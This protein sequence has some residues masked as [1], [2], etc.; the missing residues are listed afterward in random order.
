V[1]VW[2]LIKINGASVA[3][4]GDDVKLLDRSLSLLCRVQACGFMWHLGQLAL[5]LSQPPELPGWLVLWQHPT[6]HKAD[7]WP[8]LHKIMST[9]HIHID[10]QPEEGNVMHVCFGLEPGT[11][12][13]HAIPYGVVPCWCVCISGWLTVQG[14]CQLQGIPRDP[15]SLPQQLTAAGAANLA[16]MHPCHCCRAGGSVLRSSCMRW[17]RRTACFLCRCSASTWPV[18]M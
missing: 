16:I 18:A 15:D 9:A 13:T 5:Q 4:S 7:C 6:M 12:C 2:A 3:S 14:S 10:K 11:S 1:E 17:V 8:I